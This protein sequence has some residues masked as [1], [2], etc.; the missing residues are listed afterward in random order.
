MFE[1]YKKLHIG[2]EGEGGT[3]DSQDQGGHCLNYHKIMQMC[4]DMEVKLS[5]DQKLQ[6]LRA[7]K[8]FSFNQHMINEKEF[9][10][11][12]KV[13]VHGMGIR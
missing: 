13:M 3:F 5:V 9:I 4:K 6:V 12:Y 10:H 2:K 8:K 7:I 1:V 11:V